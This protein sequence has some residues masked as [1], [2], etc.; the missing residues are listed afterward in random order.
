LKVL[1]LQ[2]LFLEALTGG[3]AFKIGNV[4]VE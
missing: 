2:F 1:T 3:L 4:A